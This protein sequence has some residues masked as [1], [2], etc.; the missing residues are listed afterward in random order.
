M[1]SRKDQQSVYQRM[2]E[3]LKRDKAKTHVLPISPLGLMEMTRQ[4]AQESLI[5]AVYEACPYC[6][7]RGK[8]KSAMTMSVELQRA[9]H[10]AMRKFPDIHELK[11]VVNPHILQRLR[12]EDEEL[13]IEIERKY[14][15]RLT[16]RSDPT[17]H[18]EKFTIIDV[19]ANSEIKP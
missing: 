10:L 9:L 15:G 16:F 4:R 19:Q 14:A 5:G 17:Y 6:H 13:L 18:H 3:R 8:I 1:K 11:I 12:T 7:G 2:K